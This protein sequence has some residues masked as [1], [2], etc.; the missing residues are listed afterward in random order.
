M[1]F[2]FFTL[3]LHGAGEVECD[4]DFLLDPDLSTV[5]AIFT[6]ITCTQN[7]YQAPVRG[8]FQIFL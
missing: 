3:L 1:N 6:E 5:K 7:K 8:T 2:L 4:Y